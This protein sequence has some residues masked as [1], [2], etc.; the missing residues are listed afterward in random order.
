METSRVLLR[1]LSV[2]LLLF[3]SFFKKV[4]PTYLT[5]GAFQEQS[6]H[7]LLLNGGRM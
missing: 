7:Y 6:L 4:L 3:E 2:F 1:L 5:E